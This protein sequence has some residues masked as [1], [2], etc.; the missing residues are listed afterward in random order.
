[1]KTE[2]PP[3]IQVL[4]KSAA[5]AISFLPTLWVI[6]DIKHNFAEQSRLGIVG[7]GFLLL[8]SLYLFGMTASWLYTGNIATSLVDFLLYPRRHLKAPP[9]IITRQKGLI[10]NKEYVL[11]ETELC[12]MRLEH[13][14]SPDVA[15]LLAD[16]HAGDYFRSPETAV[17]DILYFCNHRRLRWDKQNLQIAIRCSDYYRM[18]GKHDEAFEFL[19]SEVKKKFIYTPRERATIAER[20]NAI[21]EMHDL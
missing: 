10:A 3:Q 8:G 13:P 20:A 6:N 19:A 16:L 15:L 14:E 5:L 7:D 21:A 11:A 12:E 2:W 9:V 18:L 1:M 4:T 17:A